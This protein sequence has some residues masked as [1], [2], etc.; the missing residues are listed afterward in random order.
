VG[1]AETLLE[2]PTGFTARLAAQC[3]LDPLTEVESSAYVVGRLAAAGST[4]P[5]FSSSALAALHG[6]AD[7][8]PR[9]LNR[10]ADMAL[11]I[12]YAKD[13]LVVDE[14]IVN[15]AAREFQREAA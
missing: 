8:I 14:T 4:D 9:R 12:A 1:G 6:A 2:L 3:L 10:L 15:I 7:G 5:L 11:L 13:L